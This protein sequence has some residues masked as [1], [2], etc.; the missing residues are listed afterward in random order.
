MDHSAI[1]YLIEKKDAKPRLI[2]WVLLLQEFDLEIKDK[3]GTENLIADHLSRLQL[4]EQKRESPIVENFPDEQLFAMKSISAPWYADIVNY[5]ASGVMPYEFSRQ[6]KKKF[7]VEVKHYFWEDPFLY[8]HCPDQIIRRCVP[9]E[10]VTSILNHCH[11]SPYGGHFGAN[12]TAAKVLQSG[13]YWPTI[14][15]DA[16]TLVQTCDRCQRTGNISRR[17]EAPLNNILEVK[18]F[19]VWGIDFM[20]LFHP[21]L[22][23]SSFQ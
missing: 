17:H 21:H 11:S 7:L 4:S 2:R 20:G 5:L 13:F 19:D 3:K 14:F 18:L 10:E 12:R 22:A 1:K 16:H 6:Q 8:K 9:E 23:I 15:K